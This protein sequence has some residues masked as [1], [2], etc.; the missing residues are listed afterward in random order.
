MTTDRSGWPTR[1][2]A[3]EDEG[4]EPTLDSLTPGQLVEMVRE[5]T[6]QAW[7]FKDGVRKEPRLRRDLVRV[8]RRPR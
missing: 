5:L 7:A 4:R 8:V 6:L 1:K 3:L 2:I